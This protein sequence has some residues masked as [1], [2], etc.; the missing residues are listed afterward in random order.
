MRVGVPR[1]FVSRAVLAARTPSEAIRAACNRHRAAGY[2]HLIAHVSGEMYNIEVSAEDFEVI[3]GAEGVL[4]HTNNYV[5][6]HM[7]A[8]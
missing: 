7:R 5:S 3:Y 2:N 8:R 4:A 1:I 6:P